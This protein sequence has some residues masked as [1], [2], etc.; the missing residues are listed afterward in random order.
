[1]QRV[2]RNDFDTNFS[3]ILIEEILEFGH[4]I[5][6]ESIFSKLYL[7]ENFIL[8]EVDLFVSAINLNSAVRNGDGVPVSQFSIPF[9]LECFFRTDDS[10]LSERKEPA[11]ASFLLC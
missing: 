11:P 2:C 9:P 6:H 5:K 1:M 3:L 10:S 8:Y 4:V 7:D